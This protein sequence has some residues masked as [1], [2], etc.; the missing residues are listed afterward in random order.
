MSEQFAQT[1]SFYPDRLTVWN[2][3]IGVKKSYS[4]D[5][6]S[7]SLPVSNKHAGFLSFKAKRRMKDAVNW[8]FLLADDKRIFSK[9]LKKNRTVKI[10]FVTLTLSAPQMHDDKVIK[11]KLLNQLF[12][13]LKKYYG[14]QNYVWR[15]EKQENGS[16]H[17]HILTDAFIPHKLLRLMWNRLQ[18]KL[19]YVQK[20][21]EKFSGKS[22]SEY[23][24][25]RNI[26]EK[27]ADTQ[28]KK[29]YEFGCQTDWYNPNSTDI[30][31]IAN[32]KNLAAYVTKYLTKDD[33]AHDLPT[34]GS[35]DPV[36]V[37]G[38]LWGLSHSLSNCVPATIITHDQTVTILDIIRLLKNIRSFSLDYADIYYADI[39]AYLRMLPNF[40]YNQIWNHLKRLQTLLFPDEPP[41]FNFYTP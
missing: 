22:F 21:H 41:A 25:L 39:K 2:Q 24:A 14:V 28:T 38:D 40:F 20:Y 23:C 13:E 16:I 30:H 5:N 10:T 8:L 17:F 32:K 19:G 35:N 18:T 1:I 11:S 36:F 33:Q 9:V 12:V 3:F 29:A 26:A 6:P 15:A 37:T 27:K 4:N 34:T 31:S 7:Y